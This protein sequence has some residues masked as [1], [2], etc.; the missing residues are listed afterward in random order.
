VFLL[1]RMGNGDIY[2]DFSGRCRASWPKASARTSVTMAWVQSRPQ[3]RDVANWGAVQ[4]DRALN[5]LGDIP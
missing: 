3:S 1:R 2:S 4:R 5:S